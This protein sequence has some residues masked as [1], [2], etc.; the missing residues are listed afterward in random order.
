VLARAGDRVAPK[1]NAPAG[2]C[3]FVLVGGARAC[4]M[5][6]SLRAETANGHPML[7]CLAPKLRRLVIAAAILAPIAAHAADAEN[8]FAIK[9]AGAAPCSKF[10][11]LYNAKSND[12]LLFAGWTTGYL[13]AIN[14]ATPKTFD[15][16]PWQSTEVLLFILHDLCTRAP[17]EKFYRVVSGMAQLLAEDKLSTLSSPVEMKS[18]EQTVV[19]PRDVVKKI[20]QRLTALKL[21]SGGPDGAYGPG[22]RTA[23]EAFQK[24][25]QIPETGIPDQQTLVRL[26]YQKPEGAKP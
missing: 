23:I 18:G 13:T 1:V 11:E 12:V 10:I 8:R 7:G 5:R 21:Y 24:Q 15:L 20:Q 2:K 4:M 22:T 19:L 16:A 17:D 9:G 14:Q 26:M 6:P 25:Q 3:S